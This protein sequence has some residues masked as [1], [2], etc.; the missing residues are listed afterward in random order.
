MIFEARPEVVVQVS[1]L[2]LKSGN[3]VLLKGGKEAQKSNKVS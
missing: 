2:A 1:C 3:A